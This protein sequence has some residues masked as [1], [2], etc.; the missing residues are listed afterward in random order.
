MAS[1]TLTRD[2]LPLFSTGSTI[3]QGSYEYIPTLLKIVDWVVKHQNK[4]THVN[5]NVTIKDHRI[6]K[7]TAKMIRRKLIPVLVTVKLQKLM[8]YAAY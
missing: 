6:T 7:G 4:Q 8:V 2:T 3:N 1:F 5:R